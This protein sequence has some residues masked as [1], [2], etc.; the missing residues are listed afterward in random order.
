MNSSSSGMQE[1]CTKPWF[2]LTPASYFTQANKNS[3]EKCIW[4]LK[5]TENWYMFSSNSGEANTEPYSPTPASSPKPSNCRKLHLR[6]EI[7]RRCVCARWVL[8]CKKQTQTIIC[9]TL[10]TSPKQRKSEEEWFSD[11]GFTQNMFMRSS[12]SGMQNASTSWCFSIPS[13]FT[14]A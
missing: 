6:S 7:H 14:Q 13:Y 11:L 5:V 1:A 10:A 12:S 8:N 3:W 4:D 2:C 9:L